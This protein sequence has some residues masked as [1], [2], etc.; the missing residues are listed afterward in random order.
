MNS[1]RLA[2]AFL[3]GIAFA[4]LVCVG[5]H[6]PGPDRAA[7]E[8]QLEVSSGPQP[9]WS[10]SGDTIVAYADFGLYGIDIDGGEIWRIPKR[11]VGY[12]RSPR[13]S[14]CYRLSYVNTRFFPIVDSVSK[15]KIVQLDGRRVEKVATI[16]EEGLGNGKIWSPDCSH[17]VFGKG[18][19]SN[20]A[21]SSGQIVYRYLLRLAEGPQYLRPAAY[22]WSNDSQH[23]AALSVGVDGDLSYQFISTAKR[24]G[25]NHKVI[26]SIVDY[27]QGFGGLLSVPAWSP[28]DDRIYFVAWELREEKSSVLYSM[29]QDGTDRLPIAEFDLEVMIE[30]L[31]YNNLETKISPDGSKILIIYRWQLIHPETIYDHIEDYKI[32]G[33]MMII[34]TDG[35]GFK[36]L[37]QG[38]LY[39]SWSPDSKHIAVA[40]AIGEGKEELLYIMNSDGGHV[41]TLLRRDEG[42]R[43]VGG[44]EKQP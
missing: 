15:L 41:Q 30:G 18:S 4:L 36:K 2:R 10:N 23:I 17:Y 1:V 28:D 26:A 11:S 42:G 35:T 12:D 7:R 13:L 44:T 24:D 27:R 8:A 22:A 3:Y 21:D 6:S 19:F 31:T 14:S 38:A 40:P 25:S 16:G 34:N 29:S 33:E 37:R 32:G 20:I 9:Q 39:A 43:V 5:C